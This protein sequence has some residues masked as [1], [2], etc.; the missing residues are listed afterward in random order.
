MELKVRSG[1]LEKKKKAM[2][3][4]IKRHGY[5]PQEVHNMNKES[6]LA[7]SKRLEKERKFKKRHPKDKIMNY[8]EKNG[9]KNVNHFYEDQLIDKYKKVRTK[10]TITRAIGAAVGVGAVLG[11][12]KYGS[13]V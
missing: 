8:L 13:M 6:M 3:K 2:R 4:L 1:E 12:A 9:V 10:K 5:S 11:L 7:L